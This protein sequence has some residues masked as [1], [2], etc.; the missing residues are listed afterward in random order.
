[1]IQWFLSISV[2]R[3][4]LVVVGTLGSIAFLVQMGA[5]IFA[6]VDRSPS[7]WR[8]PFTVR[9][10]PLFFAVFGWNANFVAA[11]GFEYVQVLPVGLIMGFCVCMLVSFCVG[12]IRPNKAETTD[13]RVPHTLPIIKK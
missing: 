13:G 3:Q 5:L 10:L 4:I 2:A 9:Y 7:G 6:G 11:N 8:R 12:A 1:M